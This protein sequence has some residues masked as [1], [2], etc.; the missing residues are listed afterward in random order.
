MKRI[1]MMTALLLMMLSA[2]AQ[3]DVVR[4]YL[5]E[6]IAKEWKTKTIT[7]VPTG[8]L[9]IMLERFN[10][11]WP[12]DVVGDACSVM[13]QGLAEKML[14]EETGYK[15]INDAKN[16]YV[17]VSD[18]G[19]DGAY[20]SACV[21][22]RTNGHR[23]F[24]VVIGKPTDPDIEF[25]CLYDYDP[26]TKTL[27]PEPQINEVL[28]LQ[29]GDNHVSYNLPREG[30][31]LIVL[32]YPINYIF[33]WDGMNFIFD[34]TEEVEEEGCEDQGDPRTLVKFKGAKPGIADFVLA[35]YGEAEH[36]GSCGPALK[37]YLAGKPLREGESIIV[38]DK[39]GYM[40]YEQ[41]DP[42]QDRRFVIEM[43]YWNCADGVH[44]VV[45]QNVVSFQN[46]RHDPGQYDCFNAW[47][48]DSKTH[49]EE[50]VGITG[51]CSEAFAD[52]AFKNETYLTLPRQGKNI[53][54]VT[55]GPKGLE[56]HLLEWNGSKFI[57]K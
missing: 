42:T 31:N 12:T 30:K 10:Q 22:R 57:Y 40:Q 47:I 16:G 8:G 2:Q 9:G 13:E 20:M 53:R 24:A 33:K 49:Y 11:T 56:N 18:Y 51:V 3:K 25:I 46:G 27:T 5:L 29:V 7:N 43:C 28:T 44:K 41:K 45:I 6:D 36:E 35:L 34:K 39:N 32:D 54:V 17:E 50:S 23:L 55:K 1:V 19:T 38:D 15:V 14:D 37:N 4:N 52:V 26:Q 21:W 48:Y